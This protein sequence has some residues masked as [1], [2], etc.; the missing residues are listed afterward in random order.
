M[1]LSNFDDL[2]ESSGQLSHHETQTK[3]SPDQHDQRL[4]HAGPD[5][6]FHAAGNCIQR[7]KK[8]PARD[9]PADRRAGEKLQRQ[10]N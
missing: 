3:D 1:L 8:G 10:R 9:H 5:D 7:Y 2:R 4:H 6:R